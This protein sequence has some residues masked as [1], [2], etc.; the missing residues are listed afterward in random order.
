MHH[1]LQPVE[2][3]LFNLLTCCR[4]RRHTVKL[5]RFHFEL[6]LAEIAQSRVPANRVVETLDVIERLGLSPR[7][8][9]E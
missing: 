1:A 8:G 2:T 3:W 9:C 7:A 5:S 4:F 6:N